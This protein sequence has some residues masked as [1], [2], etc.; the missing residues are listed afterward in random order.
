MYLESSKINN[1]LQ[2]VYVCACNCC[3][4]FLDRFD[5]LHFGKLASLYINGTFYFDQNPPL[6][7]MT[8]AAMGRLLGFTGVWTYDHIGDGKYQGNV[9]W[10]VILEWKDNKHT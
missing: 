6:G 10:I 8:L 7:V 1:Y 2:F 3:L 5:E 9:H 4:C